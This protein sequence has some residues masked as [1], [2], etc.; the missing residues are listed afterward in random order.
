MSDSGAPVGG[1]IRL[2]IAGYGPFVPTVHVND[3][4]VKVHYGSQDVPV[5]AGRAVV[6]AYVTAAGDYGHAEIE[7]AVAP[8]TVQTVH[9]TPPWMHGLPGVMGRRAPAG[10]RRVAPSP[11]AT[12]VLALVLAV[13]LYSFIR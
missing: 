8:G 6:R 7:V 12:L 4:L 5:P 13:F 9:Y 1:V 10:W 11:A 3:R 2:S